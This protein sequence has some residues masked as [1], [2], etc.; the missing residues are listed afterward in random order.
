M[1]YLGPALMVLGTLTQAS[2]QVQAGKTQA[3]L[4]EYNAQVAEQ[5]ASLARKRGEIEADQQRRKAKRLSAQQRALYGASGVKL[6]GSP[7]QVLIDT[8]MEQEFDARMIEY[9]ASIESMN[10]MSDASISLMK[11][12]QA[13]SSSYMNAG[14]TLLTG[15]GT[16]MR[17]A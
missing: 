13:R 5:Q 11:A 1:S 3:A 7:A 6:T 12:Q 4:F 14:S 15:V 2:S 16:Y 10:A 9:N 8:A 17:F